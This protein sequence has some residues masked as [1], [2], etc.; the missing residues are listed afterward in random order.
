MNTKTVLQFDSGQDGKCHK[1]SLAT[2]G[3]AM[4]EA[5]HHLGI[6][7]GGTVWGPT[8]AT[9]DTSARILDD[10]YFK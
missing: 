1:T 5:S 4:P 2:H 3:S 8:H 10:G 7:D 9:Q 6:R